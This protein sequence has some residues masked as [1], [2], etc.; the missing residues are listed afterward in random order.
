EG[1]LRHGLKIKFPLP[2]SRSDHDARNSMVAVTWMDQVAVRT[3]RQVFIAKNDFNRLRRK[4]FFGLRSRD[5][6]ND[7]GRE[8]LK[9]PKQRTA[10][11][12]VRRDDQ[13][14]NITRNRFAAMDSDDD[15]SRS[16]MGR[17]GGLGRNSR[18]TNS[19]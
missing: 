11:L 12:D 18:C 3:I 16:S 13:N 9:R 7:V 2:G 1:P 19:E 15:C 4:H 17:S 10:D 6:Y 8:R 14:A 5:A